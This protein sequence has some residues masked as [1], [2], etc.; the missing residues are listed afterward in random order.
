MFQSMIFDFNGTILDDEKTWG[1]SFRAVLEDFGVVQEV[2]HQ[3]GIGVTRNWKMYQEKFDQLKNEN[4]DN[5]KI[6][7][8]DKYVELMNDQAEYRDGFSEFMAKIDSK[9]LIL[10]LATSLDK[11]ILD[12]TLPYFPGLLDYFKI[13]V[14]GDE[15]DNKKPAP[16]IFNL[17]LFRINEIAAPLVIKPQDCLV[18]EDSAAGVKSAQSA[19]MQVVYMPN[20]EVE[21]AKL[22]LSPL[23]TVKDF[24]D[25][26]ILGLLDEGGRN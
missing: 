21:E 12:Q 13:V 5:L 18:F 14:T 23:L 15:V 20:E 6:K 26:K 19:G 24:K 4:L 25:E 9:D 3:P 17:T 7:T 2:S 8:L 11:D 16:D 10:A 1:E 22:D